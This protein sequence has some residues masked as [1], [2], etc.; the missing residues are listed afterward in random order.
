VSTKQEAGV[1]YPM[2]ALQ[3]PNIVFDGEPNGMPSRSMYCGPQA[4]DALDHVSEVITEGLRHGFFECTISCK[5]ANNGRREL[6][7]KAGLSHQ[8]T[9][10]EDELP[11]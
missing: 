8:F 2:E 9:I 7:V 11:R 3:S 1:F 10:P 6:Q 5:I 4:Q